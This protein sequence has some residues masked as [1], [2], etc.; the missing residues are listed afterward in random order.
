LLPQTGRWANLRH[1]R[2]AGAELPSELAD[3]APYV[4]ALEIS[5]S[6][7]EGFPGLQFIARLESLKNLSLEVRCRFLGGGMNTFSDTVVDALRRGGTIR[8]EW[9]LLMESSTNFVDPAP[10]S[11]IATRDVSRS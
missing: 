2:F 11:L 7:G 1:L 6:E 5:T 10:E 8:V 3:K 9:L 4:E